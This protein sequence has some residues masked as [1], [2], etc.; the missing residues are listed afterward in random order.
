MACRLAKNPCGNPCPPGFLWTARFYLNPKRVWHGVPERT[1]PTVPNIPNFLANLLYC[2][3]NFWESK[4]K[5]IWEDQQKVNYIKNNNQNWRMTKKIVI[6]VNDLNQFFFTRI[7]SQFDRLIGAIV[8]KSNA[9]NKLFCISISLDCT[10]KDFEFNLE[11]RT[12]FNW[13]KKK[14]VNHFNHLIF[15]TWFISANFWLQPS[16]FWHISLNRF[17]RLSTFNL[18]T[19]NEK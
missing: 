11:T 13:K 6:Y 2:K 16:I 9:T 12:L 5:I 19:N 15:Y 14:K 8:V 7:F 10:L 18:G 3:K 1:F 17:C 4:R